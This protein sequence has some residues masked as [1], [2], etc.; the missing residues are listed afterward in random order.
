LQAEALI[1][2]VAEPPALFVT[3][4]YLRTQQTAA[5]LLAKF[6]DVPV[7]IWPIQEFDCLLPEQCIG[8]TVE[9]RRSWVKAYWES[10]DEDFVH[11]KA[12]IV[13]CVHTLAEDFIVVFAHGHVMRLIWLLLSQKAH[14]MA[15]FLERSARLEVPNT[16]IFKAVFEETG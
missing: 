7:E 4:P 6:P 14:K 9:Q 16:V 12:R 15:S 2:H 13:S 10:L 1:A 5:P 8:T 3:S 11:G